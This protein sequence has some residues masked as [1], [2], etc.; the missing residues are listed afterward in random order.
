VITRRARALVQANRRAADLKWRQPP[1]FPV[2]DRQSGPPTVY[3]LAPD[4]SSHSG[5]VRVIYRQVDYLNAMGIPAAVVHSKAGFRATWFT[6]D[7][8]VVAPASVRLGPDDVLVVPE[9]YGPGIGRLPAEARTIIFNQGAYH[10]FDL[11]PFETTG[12]GSP[13]ADIR[14]LVGM[15]TVSDDSAALLRYAFPKV[16][17]HIVRAVIDPVLFHPGTRRPAR[18]VAFL[19]HRRGQERD[20]LLHILRARGVLDGWEL[21]PISGRSDRET[22]AMMRDSALFLAFSEREGFG[23][24]PAEAMASGCYVIGYTGMGGREFFDPAYCAPVPDGDLLAFAKA[25]EEACAAYDDDADAFTKVGRTASERILTQY[26]PERL[27]ADLHA[28]YTEL[29]FGG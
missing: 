1:R 29:G 23:L 27:R 14:H 17:L 3:Y 5:G 25:V 4:L 22:A 21:V 10:T 7:T 19:T 15:L 20:Q 9:C 26:S 28:F 8:R 6:N 18:Q 13:Y 2:Q 24:P 12:P 16:P 11:I